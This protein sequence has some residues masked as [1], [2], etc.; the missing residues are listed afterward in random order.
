MTTKQRDLWL[1]L[2]KRRQR[3]TDPAWARDALS[4]AVVGQSTDG[5]IASLVEYYWPGTVIDN[6]Q[7]QIIRHILSG[8]HTDLNEVGI[9]GCTKAGKGFSVALASCLWF[10]A[11]EECKIVVTS[12]RH[13]HA[14]DVMFGEILRCRKT[15][16]DS[17]AGD[18]G[19]TRIKAHEQKYV[20]TASPESG[21]GFS[22]QHGPA[23]LFIFD[24]ATAVPESYWDLGATQAACMV[25]LANPRTMSGWF[26]RLFPVHA[27]DKTQVLKVPGGRRFLSTVGGMDCINVKTGKKIIANQIDRA[28]YEA[29]KAHPNPRWGRVFGDG[30][31]PED[32]EDVLVVSPAWIER[33]QNA[34]RTDVE[35]RVFGLDV[36]ASESGDRTELACGGSGGCREVHERREVD[37]MR[38]VAWTLQTAKEY[39][40]DLS[41]GENYI[42]VD[43]DGLGK[44]VGDRLRELGCAVLEFRG[45]AKSEVDAKQYGNLRAEAYGEL[46]RRLDPRGPW[47]D[48]PFALPRDNELIDDLCAPE[49]LYSSDGIQFKLTPK[50]KPTPTYKGE[51][52]KQKLGRSPDKGDALVYM[53]AAVREMT[54]HDDWYAM[55]R[56]PFIASGEDPREE[57]KPLTKEEV[58]TLP[59]YLRELVEDVQDDYEEDFDDD[60]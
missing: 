42:A 26:R 58:A 44:G 27:T 48:E 36:A 38:V 12:Q 14:H 20:I 7:C 15:M 30:K 23:T 59:D 43:M 2:L 60:W 6:W 40:I 1:K 47:P 33:H 17:C 51:T 10:Q 31:F 56:E 8:Q 19:D 57:A 34:W 11:A 18:N 25:A 29:I 28:R 3:E 49:K 21:E 4:R 54:K 9:K 39:G 53:Y 16:H 37:T 46:G 50:D 55:Q 52:L 41:D 13:K 22:G 45:N 24:E 35:V 5:D 32:D